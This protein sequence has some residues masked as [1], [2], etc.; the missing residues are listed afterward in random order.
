MDGTIYTLKY[1]EDEAARYSLLSPEQRRVI[2]RFL[3]LVAA[4]YDDFAGDADRA[5]GQVWGRCG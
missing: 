1:K 2:A 4:H 3:R 5:L